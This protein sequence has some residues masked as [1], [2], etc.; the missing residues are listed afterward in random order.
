MVSRQQL[1]A[2]RA[3]ARKS[4][5]PWTPEGKS[6]S[7]MNALKHGL[8]SQKSILIGDERP[9]DFEAL[10]DA[11]I[12]HYRPC[13]ELGNQAAESYA[14]TLWRL[15]RIPAIEAALAE[16]ACQRAYDEE[17]AALDS[18]HEQEIRQEAEVLCNEEYDNDPDQILH[19]R[20]TGVHQQRAWEISRELLA[21]RPF[22][23][24]E[25]KTLSAAQ[26]FLKLL[27]AAE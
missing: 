9:E 10:R 3:N 24:P 12:T 23:A 14:A 21:E 22:Q 1:E 26:A 25:K 5:G 7:K 17:C 19:D 15:R 27:E 20:M 4:T 16:A 8:S 6:R 11:V 18:K 2:N 13:T